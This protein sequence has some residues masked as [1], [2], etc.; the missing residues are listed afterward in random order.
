M[1]Q[2][3]KNPN[4]P[5]GE[6][7]KSGN[8]H[9]TIVKKEAKAIL[10]K[11]NKNKQKKGNNKK[12]PEENIGQSN[13]NITSKFTIKEIHEPNS[14]L[15]FRIFSNQQF[16]LKNKISLKHFLI[17]SSWL[18]LTVMSFKL[19]LGLLNDK[20]ESVSVTQNSNQANLANKTEK[21][22]YLLFSSVADSISELY[23]S[24]IHSTE[25]VDE[26]TSEPNRV[27]NSEFKSSTWFSDYEAMRKTV[28]LYNEIHP[29]IYG[30]RGGMN[31]D[32]RIYNTW[33]RKTGERVA[34]LRRLNPG[35]KIIPTIFRWENKK[36][37]IAENIGMNGRK[38]IRDKHIS[39][40]LAEIE[41]Y[42]FDGIDIDYE[43]M[44]CEKKPKFEEFIKILSAKLKE[45]GKLLSVAVHP[46]TASSKPVMKY[47]RGLGAK[48]KV[49]F[50]ETWRGP[51][52]HDY[53]FLAKYADRVKVMAYELHPRKYKNPG[54]GPQAPNEWIRNIILY[55]K[56]KVPVEK[57]FMAIP[58][59]GY[60]WGLNC[61]SKIKAVYYTDAQRLK[62]SGKNV[63]QPT[64]L[65]RIYENSNSESWYNLTKFMYIHRNKIYEDPS[66][67]YQKNGCDRVAFFMNKKSFEEKMNLL[68]SYKIGGFSFW[69]LSDDNDPDIN[70]Y[71]TKLVRGELP[72]VPMASEKIVKQNNDLIDE[73]G[74]SATQEKMLDEEP[75]SEPSTDNNKVITESNPVTNELQNDKIIPENKES[76]DNKN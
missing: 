54:P 60:D 58:T 74:I 34:E 8:N 46:K 37:K 7:V 11:V 13:P 18:F 53:E 64:D 15:N 45:R 24:T 29:F 25:V 73:D 1:T 59:Y 32:G 42:N 61:S 27:I 51:L 22:N 39:I 33:G 56:D 12:L 30:M 31:N 76:S 40:I 72:P 17:F 2:K 28:T 63:R 43:G 20:G 66:I 26:K 6:S 36:E 41:K 4:E 68:R 16:F 38:D 70:P 67:W 65:T 3:A 47:C 75:D 19:G 71:L 21:K 48:V 57:L 10:N 62:N 52:T 5:Q 23:E 35:V 50:H 49:D 14:F 55:A 69:Q 44:S 9:K